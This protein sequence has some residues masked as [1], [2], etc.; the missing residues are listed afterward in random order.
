[1]KLLKNYVLYDIITQKFD[2][3]TKTK[4]FI[5]LITIRFYINSFANKYKVLNTIH[6]IL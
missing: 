3:F 5:E 2:I 1:M 4:N 6:L